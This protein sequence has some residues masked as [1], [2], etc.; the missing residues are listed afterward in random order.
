MPLPEHN[1]LFGFAPKLTEEQRIYVDSIFDNQMTIVNAR[2]GT[3]KTTL[4]VACAKIIGKPLIYVFAPVQEK[5]MGFR[6]GKQSEKEAEYYQP[7]ID[8]LLKIN[9][10]PAKV[11]YIE[12]NPDA[13]KAGHVWVYPK[14]HV[15][16]RGTNIEE[17][18]VIIDEAQNFTRGELKKL[19]TRL[20]DTAKVIMIGHDGQIDL[21]DPK[22]SG[23]APYIEH[24][25]NEPYC[26]T[27][28][29]TK[30]FRGRLAQHA[31]DLKW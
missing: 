8:A 18:T 27:V 7:L 20:H 29:L 4:A 1:L 6:P 26:K 30:N 28:E 5:A 14:S 21:P 10:V 13:L 23:F 16:A 3:G 22:K 2:S 24:F 11:M 19:L 9:E 12:E 15:F 31:D 25:A 17:C